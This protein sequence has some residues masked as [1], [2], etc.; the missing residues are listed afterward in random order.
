MI[1]RSK[2]FTVFLLILVVIGTWIYVKKQAS[3]RPDLANQA[4]SVQLEPAING[5]MV[6]PEI[7]QLRPI[8]VV[9]EN[10]PDARPQSGLSQADIV[11]ESLTEGGITRF[12]A[13]FQTNE[14]EKV[15]SVRSARPNF[16]FL[17][18]MWYAAYVHVGG[19]DMA[20]EQI[21]GGELKNITDINEFYNGK[22]FERDNNKTAPHNAFTS[23]SKLRQWLKDRGSVKWEKLEIAKFEEQ[24]SI[25]GLTSATQIEIP[26]STPSYKVS[27]NFDTGT[28]KYSRNMNGS[29]HLDA[30]NKNPI[31]P[32]TVILQ[33]ADAEYLPVKD[34]TSVNLN[35]KGQGTVIVFHSGITMTG[36]WKYQNGK[37][38]YYSKDGSL[39]TLPRG[40]IWV[41]LLPK[42]MINKISW[43]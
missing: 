9:V 36:K 37:I 4:E 27:Y 10:H 2:L 25:E 22:L 18:N 13:L 43:N 38:E 30:T 28:K 1:M 39:L 31:T 34:T 29:A 5:V 3:Y 35:M 42:D 12:L 21:E 11:Y 7:A 40:Q 23:I 41:E 33:F 15:G 6:K 16:N 8:A 26:F 14:P 17:A 20:L 19:S 32:S 24:P